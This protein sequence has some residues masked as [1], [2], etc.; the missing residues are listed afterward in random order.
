MQLPFDLQ[1]I[2]DILADLGG[3]VRSAVVEQVRDASP[4]AT[5]TLPQKVGDQLFNAAFCGTVRSLFDQSLGM[6]QARQQGLRIKLHIDPEDP[7]LAIKIFTCESG[8]REEAFNPHNSN[9]TWD[10]GLTQVNSVHGV[11]KAMLM[12]V[13]VNMAVARVIYERAGNSF[14]PWVCARKV[15]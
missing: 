1:G 5:R 3:M 7:E 6:T 10:A 13:D 11:S 9:G 4:A 2:G 8:L 15:K 14:S 12:D